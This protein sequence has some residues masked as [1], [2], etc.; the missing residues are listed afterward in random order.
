TALDHPHRLTILS[1]YVLGVVLF[2][3]LIFPMTD[4]LFYS[5]PTPVCT[6]T[7]IPGSICS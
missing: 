2:F 1:F 3:L 7:S 5:L 4:P 6:L